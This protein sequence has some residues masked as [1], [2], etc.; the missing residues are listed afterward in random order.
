M[1]VGVQEACLWGFARLEGHAPRA[2]LNAGSDVSGERVLHHVSRCLAYT[3]KA[4]QLD[5]AP[6]L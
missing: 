4:L 6:R 1:L 3:I 5:Y 2:V